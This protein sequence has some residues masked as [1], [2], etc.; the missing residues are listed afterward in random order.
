[1]TWILPNSLTSAFALDTAALTWGSDESCQACEQSLMRRSKSL[2]AASWR[3]VWTAGN[4]ILPRYGLMLRPSHSESF[5]AAWISSLGVTPASRS[6]EPASG[7]AKTTHG[8]SGPSSQTAFDFASQPSASS[9]TSK[10]TSALGSEMSSETWLASVTKRRGEYSAR[11]KSAHRTRESECSSW[12]TASA[13]DWKDTPGMST[14]REGNP[15]GRVDQLAR[16][17][18]HA[19]RQDPVSPSTLGSRPALLNP[20][21][22]EALMGLPAGWTDCASSATESSPQ[23]QF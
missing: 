6:A 13:R 10:D 5:T 18:Y 12:P 15:M 22:V 23:P 14:E 20:D 3:R 17:V 1:M 8:I 16:A 4:L 7:L 2:P 21:W 9:R 11:L 19:G